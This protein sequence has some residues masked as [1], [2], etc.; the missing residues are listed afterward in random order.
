MIEYQVKEKRE[1]NPEI[2][3]STYEVQ[4][5]LSLQ[6]IIAPAGNT[7]MSTCTILQSSRDSVPSS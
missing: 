7:Y 1:N 5:L 3:R 6:D 2:C 4:H